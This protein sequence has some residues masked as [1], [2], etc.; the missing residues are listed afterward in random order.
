MAAFYSATLRYLK[1]VKAAETKRADAVAK[2]TG[3]DGFTAIQLLATAGR[4]HLERLPVAPS[5]R[6]RRTCKNR[7]ALYS[8]NQPPSKT[9]KQ[10]VEDD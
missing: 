6:L 7:S 2:R 8:P 5:L 9:R 10:A 3:H 1:A 4:D